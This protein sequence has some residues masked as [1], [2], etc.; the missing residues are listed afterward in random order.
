M[1]K[2]NEAAEIEP[3]SETRPLDLVEYPA[4]SRRYGAAIAG[5]SVFVGT[6]LAH[7]YAYSDGFNPLRFFAAPALVSGVWLVAA[8][9]LTRSAKRA[10]DPQ[11]MYTVG[12]NSVVKWAAGFT[13]FLNY[14][15]TFAFGVS[16]LAYIGL[17]MM[18]MGAVS[19][20]PSMALALMAA[21][22]LGQIQRRRDSNA[23]LS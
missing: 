3:A 4:L 10:S 21:P 23:F 5:G 15:A 22:V 9:V 16:D 7:L 12:V 8:W 6:L 17:A 2:T 20:I 18:V 13:L 1:A 14:L 11:Q 19:L